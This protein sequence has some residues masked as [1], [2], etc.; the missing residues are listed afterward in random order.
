[1][2]RSIMCYR[3]L[4][5]LQFNKIL[6]IVSGQIECDGFD[7]WFLEIGAP[8]PLRSIAKNVFWT[9]ANSLST[10]PMYMLIEIDI[11]NE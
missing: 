10:N 4:R 5:L 2:N 9:L 1:M 6:I 3:K 11:F 8:S 7:F